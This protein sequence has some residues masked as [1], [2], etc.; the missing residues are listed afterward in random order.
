MAI[1]ENWSILIWQNF[2][3]PHIPI[4]SKC[5]VWKGKRYCFFHEKKTWNGARDFCRRVGSKLLE[6][7]T[8]DAN[9][10][11]TEASNARNISQFWIGVSD[12]QKESEFRYDSNGQKIT[13]ENWANSQPNDNEGGEDCTSVGVT[14]RSHS[15]GEGSTSLDSTEAGI[16]YDQKCSFTKAFVCETIGN[17]S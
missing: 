7:E 15:S 8:E 5:T 10:H 14:E 3:I 16:W 1:F 11:V 13:W 9:N 2:S 12:L 6:P 17:V 4:E